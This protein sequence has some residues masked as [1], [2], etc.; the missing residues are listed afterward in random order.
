[1]AR[2]REGVYERI[3]RETRCNTPRIPKR[4]I[5]TNETERMDKVKEL[6]IEDISDRELD[7]RLDQ[8]QEKI[9]YHEEQAK[10]WKIAYKVA[11]D[12]NEKRNR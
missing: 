12:E 2:G 1:M 3:T 10:I 4:R 5:A 8:C 7:L 6:F 11:K 9:L